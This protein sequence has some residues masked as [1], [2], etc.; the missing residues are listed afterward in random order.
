MKETTKVAITMTYG[1]WLAL[2]RSLSLG[3]GE[4]EDQA[5]MRASEK[6][7]LLS[8]ARRAK[9]KLIKKIAEKRRK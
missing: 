2:L 6:V 5:T 1:D 4:I 3:L 7:V 9:D 8:E